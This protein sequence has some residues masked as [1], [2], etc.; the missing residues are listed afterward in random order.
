MCAPVGM[1]VGTDV[2]VKPDKRESML[3]LEGQAQY[4]EGVYAVVSLVFLFVFVCD[5]FIYPA[6]N[7]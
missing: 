5:E 1:C 6:H 2:W 7:G 4:V 3:H